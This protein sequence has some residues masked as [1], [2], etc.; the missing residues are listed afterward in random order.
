MWR[1]L[2]QR[3]TIFDAVGLSV[4]IANLVYFESQM[5]AYAFALALMGLRLTSPLDQK[6][7]K[8]GNGNGGA[9]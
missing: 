2:I 9:D 3:Q 4:G 1:S 5:W 8:G 7:S 6:R